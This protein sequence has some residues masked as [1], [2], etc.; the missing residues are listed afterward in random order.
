MA[1]WS[2][3]Y[4][5]VIILDS[6]WC[7]ETPIKG[8]TQS[9]LAILYITAVMI[10]TSIIYHSITC[11]IHRESTQQ[12]CYLPWIKHSM[13]TMVYVKTVKSMWIRWYLYALKQFCTRA[14]KCI[15]IIIIITTIILICLPLSLSRLLQNVTIFIILMLSFISLILS[16][17]HCC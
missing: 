7:H 14:H 1:V 15:I 2:I 8:T 11:R 12:K 16:L 9:K 5:N 10:G 4:N 17:H 13:V 3:N 6:L